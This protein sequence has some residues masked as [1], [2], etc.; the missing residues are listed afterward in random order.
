MH[1]PLSPGKNILT[2][3]LINLIYFAIKITVLSLFST[4]Y[5]E[6]SPSASLLLPPNP[7]VLVFLLLPGKIILFKK[8]S[9]PMVCLYCFPN[10]SWAKRIAKDV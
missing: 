8:K 3:S 10:V 7:S 2:F 9:S 1:N 4:H 6:K 5:F